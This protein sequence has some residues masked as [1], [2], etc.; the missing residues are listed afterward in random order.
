MLGHPTEQEGCA[1]QSVIVGGTKR[2]EQKQEDERV[3]PVRVMS[4]VV[5]TGKPEQWRRVRVRV[6]TT[7][8]FPS[9]I[10]TLL[11]HIHQSS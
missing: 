8:I 3:E 10:A 11:I 2:E 4:D 7:T 6:P 5:A 9:L 1:Y